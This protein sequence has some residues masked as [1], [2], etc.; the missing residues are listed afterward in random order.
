MLRR[1][2]L[3]QPLILQYSYAQNI[4]NTRIHQNAPFPCLKKRSK[5][6]WGGF[7]PS[8]SENV[9]PQKGPGKPSAQGLSAAL[10]ITSFE[11]L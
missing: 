9:I 3:K 6:F 5:I 1:P 2:S 7:C 8:G 11:N 10:A 4:S